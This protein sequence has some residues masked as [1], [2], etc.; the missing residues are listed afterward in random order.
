MRSFVTGGSGGV[1]SAVI[2]ELISVGHQVLAMACADASAAAATKLGADVLRSGHDRTTWST[3]CPMRS[4]P[5]N[6]RAEPRKQDPEL[7]LLGR[8]ER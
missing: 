3:A 6:S 2:S 1:G 4:E 5:C 8:A 7:C